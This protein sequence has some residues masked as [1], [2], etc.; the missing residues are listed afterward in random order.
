MCHRCPRARI[1]FVGSSSFPRERDPLPSVLTSCL[2]EAQRTGAVGPGDLEEQIRQ[3]LGFFDGLDL[4]GGA[5]VVDLGSG[6]GLPA[7]PLALAE[8]KTNW[9]LVEAWSRR[10]AMLRRFVRQLE[11]Q[12]RVRVVT[13]RAEDLGRGAER[14]QADIVVARS[15]GPAAVALECAAPLLRVGG[16]AVLSVHADDGPWPEDKLV[17]LGLTVDRNWRCGKFHYRA[18]RAIE[19]CVPRYPRSPGEPKQ[20]PLF[21]GTRRESDH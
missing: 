4:P 21:A 7:L 1:I 9:L 19:L 17:L 15:F 13:G 11:L 3:A 10:A 8:P 20:R 6:G 12:Q 16:V 14:G 5:R 2:R 18:A